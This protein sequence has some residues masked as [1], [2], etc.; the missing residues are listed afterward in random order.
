MLDVTSYWAFW[1]THRQKI[2]S[3]LVGLLLFLAGWQLGRVTSPYYAASPIIFEDRQCSACSSSG[4]S[5]TELQ[6]LQ[7]EGAATTQ[8]VAGA[9]QGLPVQ[10]GTFVAS[11]NS[12]LYHHSTCSSASRIKPENQLWF[13]S[14]EEAEAAG[15][16]PSACT[17]EKFGE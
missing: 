15:Y 9:T 8:A 5:L 17:K 12:D 4:G 16:L 14:A 1:Q 11:V 6:A 7:G 13:A 10:A 3:V 2:G